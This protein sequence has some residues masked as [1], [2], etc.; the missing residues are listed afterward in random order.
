MNS[1]RFTIALKLI[2]LCVVAAISL[3]LNTQAA[4]PDPLLP[5]FEYPSALMRKL[6]RRWNC[7]KLLDLKCSCDGNTHVV[8]DH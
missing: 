4:D 6:Q 8:F 2:F 3:S 1:R 5:P 7:W